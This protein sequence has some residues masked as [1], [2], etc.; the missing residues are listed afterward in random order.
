MSSVKTRGSST[1]RIRQVDL[2]LVSWPLRDTPLTTGLVLLG[3]IAVGVLAGWLS[4]S[5]SMGVLAAVA[6]MVA[7]WKLWI[8]II[9]ELG[10]AG[11]TVGVLRWRRH[12]AWHELDRFESRERGM[13]FYTER[14][15]SA[16]SALRSLY[17]PWHGSREAVTE[18]CERYHPSVRES[19]ASWRTSQAVPP[20][21]S[22]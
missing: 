3:C 18:I 11:V 1:S 19:T 13:M 4:Q 5:W 14:D 2:R 9:C 20:E 12:I 15:Q 6:L 22:D 21:S 10:P 17:L 16:L 8:P 7:T